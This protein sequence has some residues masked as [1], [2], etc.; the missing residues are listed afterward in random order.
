MIIHIEYLLPKMKTYSRD[1]ASERI[2]SYFMTQM[3]E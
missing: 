3:S 1:Y 2:N